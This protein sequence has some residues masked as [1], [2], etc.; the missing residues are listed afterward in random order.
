MKRVRITD[1][2]ARGGIELDIDD[3]GGFYEFEYDDRGRVTNRSA[4]YRD[5]LKDIDRMVDELRAT[6]RRITPRAKK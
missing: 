4:V 2:T 6:R 5:I 3:F 1:S